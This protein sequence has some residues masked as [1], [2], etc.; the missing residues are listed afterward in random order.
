[1]LANK[2]I[3]II[4]PEIFKIG[5]LENEACSIIQP[6]VPL[7]KINVK[8]IKKPPILNRNLF[9][10]DKDSIFLRNKSISKPIKIT[11]WGNLF[12]SPKSKSRITADINIL[13]EVFSLSYLNQLNIARKLLPTSSMGREASLPLILFI[14]GLPAS[15]SATKFFAKV[16]S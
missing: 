1:M 10:F 3:K 15:H 6:D 5:T 7:I 2:T 11:G 8:V 9:L 13:I 12:G 16:P 14:L 4:D